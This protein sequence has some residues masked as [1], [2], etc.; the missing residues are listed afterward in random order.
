MLPQLNTYDIVFDYPWTVPNMGVQNRVTL[1]DH[2][3]QV[4][5]R[6]QLEKG[7]SV[8]VLPLPDP[9][10]LA[11]HAVCVRV[12]H[13]SGAAEALDELDRD[14]EDALVLAEDGASA[15]LLYMRLSPL[16]SATG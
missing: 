5:Q 16:V 7:D 9:R 10:L 3:R 11:L 4:A 2:T 6:R 15:N 1:V 14:I 12:A 8:I 13:M